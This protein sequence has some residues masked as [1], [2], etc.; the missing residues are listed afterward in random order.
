MTRVIAYLPKHQ[1]ERALRMWRHGS[2]TSEIAYTLVAKEA[3]VYNTLAVIRDCRND[4]KGP[5]WRVCP[6]PIGTNSRSP[7]E[8]SREHSP[9][10]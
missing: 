2:D 4:M 8:T 6:K 9:K 7:S 10:V 5:S 1:I 3:E